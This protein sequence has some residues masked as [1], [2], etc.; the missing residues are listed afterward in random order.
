[1]WKKFFWSKIAIYWSLG[2]HKGPP[3]Y[4]RS[5]QLSKG[6]IQ[7][8][9]TWNFL[10]F[11]YFCESLLPSWIRIHW[12]DW[13]RIRIMIRNTDCWQWKLARLHTNTITLHPTYYPLPKLSSANITT[14]PDVDDW[15]FYESVSGALQ[16]RE[17]YGLSLVLYSF[18]YCN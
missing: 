8:F 13:I 4:K 5:L 17:I 9:E 1:M 3:S 6:N 18:K 12:P 7:H 10:T 2:L 11:S 15:G 16:G 14:E